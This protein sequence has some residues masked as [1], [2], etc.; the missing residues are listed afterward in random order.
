[1]KSTNI[2]YQDHLPISE[3]CEY[4]IFEEITHKY[5]GHIVEIEYDQF[6]HHPDKNYENRKKVIALV[7]KEV[8]S[9]GEGYYIGIQINKDDP[10]EFI[11]VSRIY[12]IKRA[13]I[14]DSTLFKLGNDL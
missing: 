11:R 1:M 4:N 2:S 13:R 6:Y 14:N 5:E 12:N 8:I 3:I 10:P 7:C 9:Q